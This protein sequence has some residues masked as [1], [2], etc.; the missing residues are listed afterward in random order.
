MKIQLEALA[1]I[2][3]VAVV[4][5]QPQQQRT[6]AAIVAAISSVAL[7]MLVAALPN[8]QTSDVGEPDPF[9]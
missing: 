2:E 5:P 1:V 6:S 8:S 4:E 3:V 9:S 7:P